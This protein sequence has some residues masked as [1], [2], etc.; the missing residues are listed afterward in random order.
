MELEN[1]ELKALTV[2]FRA[3]QAIQE[4]I[5]K[6]VAS[7]DLNSTEFAVLELLY[8]KGEQPIQTVGKKILIASSSIT[9]VIDKLEK[10]QLVLRRDCPNDR[11]VIYATLTTK[12]NELMDQI[13]PLHQE[14]V[15][16]IFGCLEENELDKII[17][18]MKKIGYQAEKL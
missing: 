8:H 14:K 18:L 16:G 1:K 6:D 9:Y 2:I 17:E 12:G 15:A 13:F 5:R 7:Y 11:R 10:K 4:V 3:S